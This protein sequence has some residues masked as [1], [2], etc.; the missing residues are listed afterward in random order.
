MD[1]I[2]GKVVNHLI[3]KSLYLLTSPFVDLDRSEAAREV[4]HS[5]GPG[6][7]TFLASTSQPLPGKNSER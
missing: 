3:P 7:R 6:R 2:T 5:L 4:V 1:E